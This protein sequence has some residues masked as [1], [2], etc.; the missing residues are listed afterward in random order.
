M[1]YKQDGDKKVFSVSADVWNTRH[2]DI[3]CGGQ[4]LDTIAPYINNPVFSEILRLWKLYHLNDLHP[5]CEHQ[6]A[7]GWDKLASKKVTLH[8]WRMTREA[9][10]KQ[11]KAG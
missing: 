4:C 9:M 11:D 8:H 7:A 2:S 6:H 1:E 10:S 5:E 3:V